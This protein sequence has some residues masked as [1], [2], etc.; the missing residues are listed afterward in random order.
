MVGIGGQILQQR[1]GSDSVYSAN[2]KDG[3]GFVVQGFVDLVSPLGI[4]YTP[5]TKSLDLQQEFAC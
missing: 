2:K 1:D 3:S 4:L 5:Y